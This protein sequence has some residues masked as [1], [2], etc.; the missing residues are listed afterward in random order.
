LIAALATVPF[1]GTFAILKRLWDD[2]LQVYPSHKAWTLL[3]L[4][5]VLLFLLA[6]K[7]LAEGLWIGLTGRKWIHLTWSFGW[8]AVFVLCAI[9]GV[10]CYQ[11]PSYREYLRIASPW[12]GAVA[13]LL[14]IAIAAW[15][16]RALSKHRLLETRSL[17]CMVVGWFL[18]VACLFGLVQWLL[19]AGLLS[20]LWL[21]LGSLFAVPFAQLAVMPL[22]LEWNRHR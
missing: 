14:K 17:A 11:N 1:N 21:L 2:C 18:A 8:M 22:A 7:S 3:I 16:V 5:P 15:V 4:A 10:F 6:W 9:G 13:L 20:P 19:P 12:V